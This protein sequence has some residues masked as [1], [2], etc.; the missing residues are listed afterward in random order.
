MAGTSPCALGERGGRWG[1]E[2]HWKNWPGRNGGHAPAQWH[3]LAVWLFTKQT[4]L[5]TLDV[6][7]L[8][9]LGGKLLS[10][11]SVQGGLQRPAGLQCATSRAKMIDR[12][13]WPCAPSRKR[14]PPSMQECSQPCRREGRVMKGSV[15]DRHPPGVPT[16]Q[17][18]KRA[19]KDIHILTPGTVNMLE[20][21]SVSRSVVSDSLHTPWTLAHQALLSMG[22]SRQEYWSGLPFPSPGDL[23][24][25]RD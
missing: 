10:H 7:S 13:A 20:S 17:Q 1:E 16:W 25:P 4:P 19:H 2:G 18:K 8:Q 9:A 12:E 22:F 24:Q 23:S 21:G 5:G 6:S 15:Y 11:W 14:T 3:S